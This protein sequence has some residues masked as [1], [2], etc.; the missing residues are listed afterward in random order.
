MGTQSLWRTSGVSGVSLTK[1]MEQPG[2]N[3]LRR[4]NARTDRA[5]LKAVE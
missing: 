5:L 3:E 2:T 1:C 4:C